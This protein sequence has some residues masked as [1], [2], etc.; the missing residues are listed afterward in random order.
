MDDAGGSQDCKQQAANQSKS[1]VVEE[2][3]TEKHWLYRNK[4]RQQQPQIARRAVS[5]V[6][7]SSISDL[8]RLKSKST[9]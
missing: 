8:H 2:G 6:F 5:G 7:P 1:T 9:G 3:D 4:E